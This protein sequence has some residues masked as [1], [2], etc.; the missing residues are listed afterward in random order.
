[1]NKKLVSNVTTLAAI[2][3]IT[4][5]S[6]VGSVNVFAKEQ[7]QVATTQSERALEKLPLPYLTAPLTTETT[8]ISG[9]ANYVDP[10]L[11]LTLGIP[12]IG[13][14]HLYGGGAFEY[15]LDEPLPAYTQ[16]TL[17]TLI[18]DTDNPAYSSRVTAIVQQA[19]I[20]VNEVSDADKVVS[21]VGYAN[22]V[23]KVVTPDGSSYTGTTG[24]DGKYTV[25]IPRQKA[26]AI[27]SVTST[28]RAGYVDTKQVT[29]VDRLGPDE[30][31]LN[32]ANATDKV[33]TGKAEANSKIE[34]TI[35]RT[36][37]SGVVQT[38]TAKG[39]TDADG[40]FSIPTLELAE[41][42]VITATA[43]DAAG[44]ESVEAEMTVISAVQ[45]SD[46]TLNAV[47]NGATT[48]TGTGTPGLTAETTLGG[49]K[50]T[51]VIDTEGN[52]SITIPKQK[53]DT[54]V[55]V[56]ETNKAGVS[57][58]DAQVKVY[59]H[60]PQTGVITIN[61][62]VPGQQAITG[63]VPADAELVRLVVNGVAQRNMQS[64][65]GEYNIYSR[66]V[67]DKDG[68]LVRLKAGDV[69][70][71]DYGTRTPANMIVK[72]T[73]KATIVKPTVDPV[74]AKA[75]NVTGK[76]PEGTQT[77]RLT[78]NGIAQRVITPN[79][80]TGG[81]INADGTYSFYTRFVKD[82]DGNSVRLQAGDVVAVDYGV[83]IPGDTA[84]SVTVK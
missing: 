16:I 29:V 70:Q 7:T 26:G 18:N 21:G 61:D 15:K 13:N 17:Q 75:E 80:T 83:Q 9:D 8:I 77:V 79:I 43:T 47:D 28:D 65:N 27:L 20:S 81:G 66:F 54:L 33:I 55:K 25:Q 72:T 69:V 2:G 58:P 11:M 51:A 76:V 45:P 35:T 12:N 62:I 60:I 4:L 71:V 1:M 39:T 40:I 53:A 59:N 24:A 52:Y 64:V 56:H 84:T 34:I 3:I 74:T 42:D 10:I 6:S 14:I 36:D 31:E 37:E 48:I 63:K 82:A 5:S 41:G 68:K 78:V 32:V 23:A 50:Y 46:V 49:T 57:G 44:Y 73:V 67:T 30:P 38:A 19:K 22:Q